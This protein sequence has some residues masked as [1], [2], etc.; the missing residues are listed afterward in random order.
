MEQTPSQNISAVAQYFSSAGLNASTSSER[1]EWWT[2]LAIATEWTQNCK[3]Y[4]QMS[5]NQSSI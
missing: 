1:M 3:K 4:V 2:T 5:A